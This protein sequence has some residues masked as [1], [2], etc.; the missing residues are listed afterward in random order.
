MFILLI[1]IIFQATEIGKLKVSYDL[2][3]RPW[4]NPY[5]H[6]EVHHI[7]EQGYLH[8]HHPGHPH[9]YNYIPSQH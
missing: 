6:E 5:E 8:P 4:S 9:P 2:L 7:D 3:N 1:K